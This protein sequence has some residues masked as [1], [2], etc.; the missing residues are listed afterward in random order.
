MIDF[1]IKFL[2]DICRSTMI[3]NMLMELKNSVNCV[4]TDFQSDCLLLGIQSK[5]YHP[6]MLREMCGKHIIQFQN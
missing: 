3:K 2:F 5:I 1:V 6:L 4:N